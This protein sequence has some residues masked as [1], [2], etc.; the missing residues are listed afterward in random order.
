MSNT[1]GDVSVLIADD[2]PAIRRSL[3]DLLQDAGVQLVGEAANGQEAVRQC[4]RL[5]PDVVVLDIS[6]PVLNGF[7]AAE[8]IAI[9]CPATKIIFLTGHE[10]EEYVGAAFRV[11]AV[12]FVHKQHVVPGII[13][14]IEA[15]LEGKSY[16]S[17]ESAA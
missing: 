15:V 5:H 9:R 7:E 10:L 4:E 1:H 16:I 17:G 6:M 3:R 2:H 8:E 14:A 11:G 13:E 12:A